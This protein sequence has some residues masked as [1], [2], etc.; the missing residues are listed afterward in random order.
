MKLVICMNIVWY[1]C[2]V[3]TAMGRDQ[4]CICYELVRKNANDVKVS[5]LIFVM[6]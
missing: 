6:S 2:S 5:L 3:N 1:T 4:E